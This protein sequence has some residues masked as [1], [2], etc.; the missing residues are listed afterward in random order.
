MHQSF[1]VVAVCFALTAV[2]V[3]SQLPEHSAAGPQAPLSWDVVSIKPHRALDDSAM[4]R[5]LPDGFEMQNMTIHSL[6]GNA[7][8][9][10]SGDEIVG[11]PA[12]TN[13][14]RYDFRAKMDAETTDAFHKLHGKDGGDMWRLMMRQLLEDR[15]ALK[16]HIEKRE[17]PV[18]ELAIAKHGPKMK[19]SAPRESSS[20]MMSPG[21]LTA[22][23]CLASGLAGTLSGVVGR[24]V[25]DK[26]G[27]TG[28]YDVDLTWAWRDDPGSGESGP[29]IFT[30][31][32]E[33]LGLKLEP[34]KAPIDV[35][36]IDHIERPSEN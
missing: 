22:H 8:P 13:S 7:F 19:T 27:L 16:Y 5:I 33:Q 9:M 14:E 35:V 29:S 21:K 10:R 32:Q 34:A 11:W 31:L 25:I 18:Y 6:F 20:S 23:Q 36:V 15:F 17:L 4:T 3:L 30:A 1:A 12:W 24:V 2:P 28:V 26:T